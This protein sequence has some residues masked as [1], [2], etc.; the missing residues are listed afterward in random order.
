MFGLGIE[1]LNLV[2]HSGRDSK[3]T[4]RDS[5]VQCELGFLNYATQ[6]DSGEKVNIL[7]ALLSVILRKQVLMN[8]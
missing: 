4:A 2:S 3:Q 8:I 7:E 1:A 6:G 5:T